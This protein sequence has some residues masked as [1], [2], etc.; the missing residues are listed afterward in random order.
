V[1]ETLIAI[2][3]YVRRRTGSTS[4]AV[5]RIVGTV[6]PCVRL[7]PNC[8]V[9]MIS[10]RMFHNFL[11]PYEQKMARYLTPYGIHH[12]GNDM[13]KVAREYAQIEG[14]EFFDVGWGSDIAACRAA[15]PNAF[16]SLRLSPMRVAAL[17]PA[18]I[19]ADAESLLNA[20]GPLN[21]AALCCINLDD[22]VPDENVRAI[23]RV[24]EKYR[25]RKN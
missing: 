19:A 17:T 1:C 6:T 16:F 2:T 24:A 22:T 15:L 8:T 12:C 4:T 18:E 25:R 5:N 3:T 7:H 21:Q 14:A 11:L 23:F 9:Q 10:P 20:A 13:H